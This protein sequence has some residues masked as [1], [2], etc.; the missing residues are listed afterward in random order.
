MIHV[1]FCFRDKTGRYA[2]FAGTAML[3]LFENSS[4]PP[5]SI[6]VHVLHDETLTPDNRNKFIYLA[7]RY[8]QLVKFYDIAN[9]CA[10]KLA[11][12]KELIP[13]AEKSRVTVGAFYK[14]LIP[15]VLPTDIEKAIF[16]DPDTIVNLDINELWQ[17]KLGDKVLGAVPEAENG[18][19]SDK[20][21]LLCIEGRVK[22]EDYFNSGVMLMDLNVLRGEEET[23]M[24]GI[25]FRGENPK[26]N[27]FEQTVLNYCFSSRLLRLPT[28][29]NS[30]VRQERRSGGVQT[31]GRKIFHYAS[32]SSR[33]GLDMNDPANRLWMDYFIKSPWF[34]EDAIGRLYT[35]L[36]KIRDDLKDSA[37]KFSTIEP[38]KAR[39]FFIEPAKIES[40]KKIFLIRDD[41]LIIPAENE[42]SLQKLLAIMKISRDKCLSFIMT[43]KFFNKKFPFDLLEQEGFTEDKDFVKAWAFSNAQGK[44]IDSYSLIQ[45]M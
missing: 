42:D 24:A 15:Q 25:K 28:K 33:M 19:N 16:L 37:L 21:F 17:V 8:G 45:S 20:A 5:Q 13:E 35:R 18:A 34:D 27:F 38:N 14:L 3:S 7:G 10:D 43:E 40:L 11:K 6:C 36:Q 29:F 9:L 31:L 22:G 2:K 26:H 39:V 12:I 30:F 1:C 4:A 23:I 32:G 41:E 44:S